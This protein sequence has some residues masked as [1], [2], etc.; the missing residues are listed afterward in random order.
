MT[1]Y[2]KQQVI[3]KFENRKTFTKKDLRDFYLEYQPDLKEGTFGWYIS[4][5]KKQ[6]VLKA[7]GRGIYTLCDK[8]KY[9][10]ML[11]DSSIRTV[12]LLMEDFSDLKYCVWEASWLNEFSLHQTGTLFIVLEIEKE[13][14]NS[15]FYALRDNKLKNLFLQP[16]EKEMEIYVLER[17]SSIVLKT[18]IT[19]APLQEIR[20]KRRR[21]SVPTLEKILVDVFCDQGMFYFYSGAE[22]ERIF[23][24][25]FNRYLVDFSRLFAY[26]GRRGREKELR[27]FVT[28]NF[29]PLV[30]SILT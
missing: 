5:L 12:R 6:G 15:V 2:Y 22:T 30:E 18:L 8:S 26:A 17:E 28:Q 24:N 11:S 20:D 19:R 14:I 27:G 21:V 13:L 16:D 23:E 25:A 4:E 7:A 3:N 1:D 10:P 9:I 29:Q